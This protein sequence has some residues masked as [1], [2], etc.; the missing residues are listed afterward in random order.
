MKGTK[1]YAL[2]TYKNA[3]DPQKHRSYRVKGSTRAV[4][5]IISGEKTGRIQ[6][7]DEFIAQFP[8]LEE[9]VCERESDGNLKFS[10]LD[11]ETKTVTVK[12]ALAA[13]RYA[14]GATWVLDHLLA[15]TPL[16]QALNR[17]FDKYSVNKKILSLSYFLNLTEG[18]AMTRYE[19]FAASHRLPWQGT[20]TP[21]AITRIFQ[22]ITPEK[23]D[24]FIATLNSL[25]MKQADD[26]NTIKYWALDSTSL[27]TYTKKLAKSAFGHNKDGDNLSQVNVLMV[28]NQKTGEPVYYRTYSGNV[29]DIVTV[30]HLLQEQARIKLD[31]NAVLV[32][33]KGYSSISNIHRF[34]QNKTSFLLNLKT[35]FSVCRNIFDEVKTE[36]LD[37]LNYN[38]ELKN[39]FTSREINWSYPVNFKSDCRR[40]PR[41]KE[42]LFMHIY[43]DQQCYN[44]HLMTITENISRVALM[45]RRGETLT[46]LLKQI[47]DTFILEQ[48]EDDGSVSY[49]TNRKALDDYLKMKGVRI[50][51]SNEVKDPIEAYK[52]Y[53]DRNEV[54]YA[55][56]LFKQRL[57]FSRM[58]VSSNESLEGKAFVQF[59]ATSIAIMLRKRL[60]NALKNNRKLSL[61]YHSEPVVLDRLDSIIETRFSFGSYYSEVVGGLKELFKA[62]N[63]PEPN[64]EINQEPYQAEVEAQEQELLEEEL[65]R[66]LKTEYQQLA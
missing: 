17:T 12:D 59:I 39:S 10:P 31:S 35:S 30:K 55:F 21:S 27:S 29:P 13:K 49:A 34:Y 28:V 42:K 7:T 46:P 25:A 50:L 22:N 20:L 15:N 45:L 5:T 1:S 63:I 37:P 4:G 60:S 54:E 11:I 41:L 6:W 36:L 48:T 62:L 16:A 40:A 64:E 26:D 9:L 58:R 43:Y 3:W 38:S 24:S 18:N 66:G 32:A 8:V 44:S 47:R 33:D 56:R 61:A 52:A 14:A 53:F 23:I 57:G 19:N 51:V 65:N 2:Y